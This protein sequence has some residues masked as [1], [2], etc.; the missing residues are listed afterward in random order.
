VA[1]TNKPNIKCDITFSASRTRTDVEGAEYNALVG[2]E[3]L[4]RKFKPIIVS[5]F[6]PNL[7]PGISGVSGEVYLK[8]LISLGY[9]ISVINLDGSVVCHKSNV[10]EV[11]SA[12]QEAGVDSI[13]ILTIP[14]KKSWHFLSH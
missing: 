9:D 4:I 13:D 10:D 5:E 2:A 12:F 1:N 7:M 3:Q 8:Y 11:L 6:S 14:K